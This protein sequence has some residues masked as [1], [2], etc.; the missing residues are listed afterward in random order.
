MQSTAVENLTSFDP[1]EAVTLIMVDTLREDETPHKIQTHIRLSIL[2][3]NKIIEN[4]LNGS[5]FY[6]QG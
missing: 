1:E 5:R 6:D 3:S 2:V 4:N